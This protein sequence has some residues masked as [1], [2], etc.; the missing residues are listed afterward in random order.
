VVSVE[1][2]PL[3]GPVLVPGDVVPG[4]A[5]SMDVVKKIATAGIFELNIFTPL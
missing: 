5:K 4:W 2:T 1:P 3:R